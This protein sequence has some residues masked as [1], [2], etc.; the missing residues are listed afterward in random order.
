MRFVQLIVSA[1]AITLVTGTVSAQQAASRWSN[2]PASYLAASEDMHDD[3][4]QASILDECCG[5]DCC[6]GGCWDE[7]CEPLWTVNAGTVILT[8]SAPQSS[9]ILFNSFPRTTLLDANA[10]RFNWAAGADIG[11][12]R[13]VENSDA[14]DAL[15]FRY[16]G[17][18]SWQADASVV[19]SSFW[20]FPNSVGSILPARIDSSYESQL[21]SFELN[22]RRNSSY[23]WLTWLAGFRWLQLN[24]QLNLRETSASSQ[25]FNYLTTTRNNLYGAQLGAITRILDDGGPL[26]ISCASKAGIYGNAAAN[27]WN[28]GSVFLSADQRNQVAFVGDINALALYKISDHISLQGGYQLLWIQGVAVAGDQ[29]AVM[30]QSTT[31]DGINSAGGAFFHGATA[32]LSFTW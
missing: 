23:S 7:C 1:T 10:F 17:V 20:R 16:F 9:P 14:I 6:P 2:Q 30:H 22:A 8:R 27:H 31:K 13:R 28:V 29:L 5:G 18:Q 19:A 11:I 24:D 3:A 26:T 15:D 21:Y 32:G 12:I 4:A 25:V